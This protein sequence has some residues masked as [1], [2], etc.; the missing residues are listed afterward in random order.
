MTRTQKRE[1]LKGKGPELTPAQ[2]NADG[3]MVLTSI[4]SLLE[5][6][7]VFTYG[8][9]QE[10]REEIQR[11]AP[12]YQESE[13]REGSTQPLE[14]DVADEDD[15][16]KVEKKPRLSV[17]SASS[18]KRSKK[19]IRKRKSK[20]EH[21]KEEPEDD[22]EKPLRKKARVSQPRVKVKV[23]DVGIIAEDKA[24]WLAQRRR[25][26]HVLPQGA[27]PA[28]YNLNVQEDRRAWRGDDS[29]GAVGD[30]KVIKGVY[31]YALSPSHAAIV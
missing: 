22:H 31:I 12:S 4:A 9:W 27:D 16:E 18:A 19:Y 29:K 21:A 11:A 13:M 8:E 20:S 14:G 28:D 3:S 17:Q 7:Q 25:T 6:Q 2:L 30:W 5:T 15:D 24:M 26:P 1:S 10:K 23:A